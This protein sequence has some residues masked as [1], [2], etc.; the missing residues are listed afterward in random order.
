[1]NLFRMGNNI[2]I[3]LDMLAIASICD[4]DLISEVK[5]YYLG[6]HYS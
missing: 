4:I 1:M 6:L 5:L 3:V 2:T